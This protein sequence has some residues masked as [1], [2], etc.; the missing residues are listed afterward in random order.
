MHVVIPHVLRV[1][2][3]LKGLG[4]WG[5]NKELD[6]SLF[7]VV[8]NAGRVH[9]STAKGLC[10][11]ADFYEVAFDS[12]PG[13]FSLLLMLLVVRYV[14]WLLFVH[15]CGCCGRVWLLWLCWSHAQV[16]RRGGWVG[17]GLCLRGSRG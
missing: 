1:C 15:G 17:V 7:S 14:G 11:S 4:C 3:R 16:P 12:L 8:Y 6:K 9:M 2:A 10:Q 13:A 5:V